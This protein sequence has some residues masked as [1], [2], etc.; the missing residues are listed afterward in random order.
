M[1]ITVL[2]TALLAVT[3]SARS[4]T[5]QKQTVQI[6]LGYGA[7]VKELFNRRQD[8][9]NKTF[10]KDYAYCSKAGTAQD[11][12]NAKKQYFCDEYPY[13]DTVIGDRLSSSWKQWKRLAKV[14]VTYKDKKGERTLVFDIR[15]SRSQ[16]SGRVPREILEY[17]APVTLQTTKNWI[18]NWTV[19]LIPKNNNLYASVCTIM[20]GFKVDAPSVDGKY[21]FLKKWKVSLSVHYRIDPGSIEFDALDVCG[22]LKIY[23]D[24]NLSPQYEIIAL[25]RPK[26]INATLEKPRLK[27]KDKWVRFLLSIYKLFTR[28]TVDSMVDS[29]LKDYIPTEK[30]LEDGSW[31]KRLPSGMLKVKFVENFKGMV[32]ALNKTKSNDSAQT[33]DVTGLLEEQCVRLTAQIPRAELRTLVQESC[34]SAVKDSQVKAAPFVRHSPSAA[35]QCYAMPVMVDTAQ[36][37]Y[38]QRAWWSAYEGQSWAFQGDSDQGCRLIGARITG[39]FRKEVGQLLKCAAVEANVAINK[40]DRVFDKKACSAEVR[41]LALTLLEEYLRKKYGFDERL[42]Q[43]LEQLKGLVQQILRGKN[44]AEIR[45]AVQDFVE[46]YKDSADVKQALQKLDEFAQSEE[47][48]EIVKDVKQQGALLIKNYPELAEITAKDNGLLSVLA[49]AQMLELTKGV[50]L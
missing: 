32:Q 27:I 13:G 21:T 40:R 23:L 30:E 38:L 26:L 48:A 25:D 6:E 20:P 3:L 15:M 35:Q 10:Q 8:V 49:V 39:T 50:G 41:V 1:R 17:K 44:P 31:M 7:I 2:V 11:T 28:K 9:L 46:E 33:F 5:L 16:R 14:P 43:A 22:L 45:K 24:K 12:R 47:V 36:K 29:Y 37:P 42:W 19:Q 18:G 4:Q 34:V